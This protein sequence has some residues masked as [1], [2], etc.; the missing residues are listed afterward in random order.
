MTTAAA[1]RPQLKEPHGHGTA[2]AALAAAG[3]VFNI[4]DSV[5][6]IGPV[7]ATEVLI[8][9]TRARYSS[10]KYKGKSKVI[11]KANKKANGPRGSQGRLCGI[12]PVRALFYNGAMSAIQPRRRS[13]SQ[14][15]QRILPLESR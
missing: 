6:G 4:V 7:I 11:N 12:V 2:Q 15:N 14:R 3:R 13:E 5:K 10:G 8:T 9:T 1:D